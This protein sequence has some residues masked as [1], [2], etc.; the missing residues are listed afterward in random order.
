ML[1]QRI[2]Q[3][4]PNVDVDAFVAGMKDSVN[5]VSLIDSGPNA[6]GDSELPGKAAG[7]THGRI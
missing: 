3:D 6:G 4:V 5:G 1:G 7:G 2:K